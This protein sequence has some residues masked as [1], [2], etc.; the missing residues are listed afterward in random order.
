M[1]PPTGNCWRQVASAS[2]RMASELDRNIH[3]NR[4]YHVNM[5]RFLTWLNNVVFLIV[6][7]VGDFLFDSKGGSR[8]FDTRESHPP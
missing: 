2:K 8:Q 6:A 3:V 1:K 7:I 4:I 5:I